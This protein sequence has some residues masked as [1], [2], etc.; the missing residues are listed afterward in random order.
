MPTVPVYGARKVDR[1][2]L[3][4]AMLTPNAPSEA[5][6]PA[7]R[8]DLQPAIDVA[9]QYHEDQVNKA[10]EVAV[11]KAASD[12]TAFETELLYGQNGALNTEG[13]Q[14]FGTPEK[15]A[16]AWQKRSSEIAAGL[17]GD[18]QQMAFNRQ[19]ADRWGSVNRQVQEHVN[20]ETK[21]YDAAKTNDF[22]DNEREAAI[23]GYKDPE[24]VAASLTRQVAA[25][26]DFAGRHGASAD[27]VEKMV[28]AALS[29][30]HVGVIDRMLANDEDLSASEYFKKH[31]GQVSGKDVAR[32]E[33]DLEEGSLRGES[34]RQSDD[35][36]AKFPHDQSAADD[37]VKAIKDPKIR[38]EVQ[39]RV[40]FEF[41]HRREMK[42]AAQD[43]LYLRATNLID[44]RPGIIPRKA[45]PPAMWNQLDLGQRNAL[46]AR[47]KGADGTEGNGSNNDK[48]WLQFLDMTPQE[49]G[50]LNASEYEVSFRSKFGKAERT[51]ADAQW[52]ASR[53][54]VK[55]G[56]NFTPQMT[57]GQSFHERVKNGLDKSGLM[58]LDPKVKPTAEQYRQAASIEDEA[59]TLLNQFE[60]ASGKTANPI[61]HQKIV[62]EVIMR[63]VF[64]PGAVKHIKVMSRV[65]EGRVVGVVSRNGDGNFIIPYREVPETEKERIKSQMTQRGGKVTRDRIERAYAAAVMNDTKLLQS[66]LSEK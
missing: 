34:Q 8:V 62:D 21:K 45:I 60:Q 2:A 3:P 66:I 7:K 33:K 22:I 43:D 19:V 11:T 64:A 42:R 13:E 39:K 10:D 16:A 56:K 54:A 18:R 5:F 44:G 24:R 63:H 58:P 4:G 12:L 29:S 57:M 46:E 52:A 28:S 26:K 20:G 9:R 48:V 1:G 14:S 6:Q 55:N 27:T 59:N 30:T 25:I 65:E 38:D 40:D 47:A 37:A 36:V 49:L 32:V 17:K 35:I 50:K 53:D 51:R 41:A 15:V 61:E 31:K 23:L